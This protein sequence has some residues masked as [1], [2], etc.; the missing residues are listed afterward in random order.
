MNSYV[1]RAWNRIAWEGI[2]TYYRSVGAAV[3]IANPS[4]Y[5]WAT[6]P[7]E[8]FDELHRA[9]ISCVPIACNAEPPAGQAPRRRG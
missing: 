9:L 6:L 3:A 8:T 7:P 4:R 5:T 1:S 2:V